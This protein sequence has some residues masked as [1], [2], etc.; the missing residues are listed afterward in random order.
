MTEDAGWASIPNAV[1]L[2]RFLLLVPV[3][4]LLARDGPDPLS[5]ILLLVWA[6]TDWIDGLL[7]R[8]L[9]QRSRVGAIIDPIADRLGLIG[10]VLALALAQVLPWAAL[11]IVFVVDLAVLIGATGAARRGEIAVS[12]IGKARTALLMSAVFALAAASAWLPA[13]APVGLVLLWIGVALHVVA[14]AGYLIGARRGP[15]DASA[16]AEPASRR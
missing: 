1:T 5:V 9:H 13:W 2:L 16:V 6:L 3:C 7:A 4:M 15:R 11:V 14:G 8:L 12:G 10:I